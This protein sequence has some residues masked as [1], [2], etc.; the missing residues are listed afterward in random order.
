MHDLL[1]CLEIDAAAKIVAA[2]AHHRH[3][4]AGSA[5]TTLFH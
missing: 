5:E 4:K 3:E 1:R 2:E